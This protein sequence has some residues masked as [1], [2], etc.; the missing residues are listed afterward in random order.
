MAPAARRAGCRRPVGQPDDV[1]QAILL[2]VANPFV[3]GSTV[4][5]V[6]GNAITA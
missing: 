2:A 4:R 5:A 3:T 1:A 6:F